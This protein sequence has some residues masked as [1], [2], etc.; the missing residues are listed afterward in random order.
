MM[1][2]QRLFLRTVLAKF[3]VALLA[4]AFASV[5]IAQGAYPGKAVR[6]VVP[7]PPGGGIDILIRAVG[8]ELSSRWGQ[9]VIV[10]NKAGAGTLIGTDNV[11]RS[12]PDGH[13]LLATVNQT[14]TSNRFL[15]KNLPYDPDRSLAP[16]MEMVESE[17]LIVANSAVPARDLREFIALAKRDPL[18]YPFGSFGQ[19]TQ[20]HLLFALMNKR[21]STSLTHIPYKGVAPLMTAV[22]AGE[23]AVSTGSGS[24]AGGL[25]SSGRIKPLAITSKQRSSLFP[26]V[27]TALEQGYGYLDA[28][29]WYGLFAPAGT[30]PAIMEKINADVR[31]ILRDP[32]FAEKN[33]TSRNLRVVASTPQQ[34]QSVIRDEVTAVG[35]MIRAAEIKPE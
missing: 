8:A 6:I 33:V 2:F 4:F 24:V 16:I 7:F 25:I 30:P 1:N 28:T 22:A 19:G 10:D 9:P 21:E 20:P 11:A 15:Y 35:E 23:V 34:F 13:T 27:P 32:A 31:A 26:D 18:K 12:A 3:L 29:I 14:L 5:A 17:Q